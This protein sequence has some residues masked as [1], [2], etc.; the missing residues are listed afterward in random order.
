MLKL[1]ISA[2]RVISK[3]LLISRNLHRRSRPWFRKF[4]LQFSAYQWRW[5]DFL[6]SA[7]MPHRMKNTKHRWFWKFFHF[8]LTF[9]PKIDSFWVLKVSKLLRATIFIIVCCYSPNYLLTNSRVWRL[10]APS[11]SNACFTICR[12]TSKNVVNCY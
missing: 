7:T 12:S 3:D 10:A 9:F 11:F 4:N 6:Y 1:A 5:I 2:R 8:S